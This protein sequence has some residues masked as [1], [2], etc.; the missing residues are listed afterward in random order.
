MTTTFDALKI[1]YFPLILVSGWT[2][3]LSRWGV[4]FV[5]P[6]IAND[7]TGSAR[8]VQL[9]GVALW[10]PLLFGGVIGGW[11]AD[12]F[13]RRR[14]VICQFFVTIPGLMLLGWIEL[15]GEL[16]L[17]MVY[18]VLFVTGIGWVFDM[19]GRRVIVYDLV[20]SANIDNALALEA[21]GGAI[22]LA[23]GALGGGALIQT[24]GI[25]WAL[26]VMGALQIVSF[27]TFVAV[28]A[29]ERMQQVATAGVSTLLDGVRM[30]RTEKSLVSILGV[31]ACVNFFFFSSSP[32][33]QVVGG[34]FDVGPALLG[35]LAAMLGIGMFGG[36][37]AVARYQPERR[38][39]L[40]V[41]GS[42]LAFMFMIGFAL[43]PWY[44][45][46]AVC[47]AVAASG[48]GL[49][50]STQA[51]LVMDSVSEERR[52]RALGLL[53]SAIGVLPIGMLVL[54]EMAEL[55]GTSLA[56]TISVITG[57]VLM[58]IFLRIRPETLHLRQNSDKVEASTTEHPPGSRGLPPTVFDLK[59]V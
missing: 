34:K 57:A 41:G 44:I 50:A 4:S 11:I 31:T 53:S 58:T 17:W 33:L 46:S 54:G 26:I 2:W 14:V 12:R 6:F 28:P 37:L 47:L 38:G 19:V 27:S 32:L 3:N 59:P 7:L 39:L 8:M 18:P 49:F 42:Y 36:C 52:G 1:R 5:G 43:A 21:S 29:I 10:S 15:A 25:G 48:M 22:A 35:L 45:A 9:A 24:V 56:I 51:V 20:G 23:L 30:L 40:Y 16:Q 13:D 55:M